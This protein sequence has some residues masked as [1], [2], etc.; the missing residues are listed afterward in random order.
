[1]LTV[2]SPLQYASYGLNV[3]VALVWF[4]NG[5]YCKLLNFVPRHQQIV[6]TML[7]EEH[8][9][10]I[11]RLIGVSEMLLAAWVLSRIK[12]RWC[13][14]VQVVLI[15]MMNTLEFFL[16]P[17]LLLFG[18]ANAVFA[19][20]LIGVILFNEYVLRPHANKTSL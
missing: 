12:S 7:G 20:L 15:A 9:A 13:A 5:L 18:K 16:A 3:V 14:I 10:I 4:I 8:A 11:T 1:M 2:R 17:D 19:T 6:A